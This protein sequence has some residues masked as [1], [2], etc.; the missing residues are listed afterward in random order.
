VLDMSMPEMDGMDLAGEI[1]RRRTAQELPIVMLTSLGQRQALRAGQG[2]DL[3]ACLSK[4]IKAGQL[5][6]TLVA[7]LQGR[8]P[9]A[10]PTSAAPA[11][12]RAQAQPLRVLLAE[13]N[14][15]GQRV[16]KRL[17]QHLGYEPDLA[18]DGKQVLQAVAR[19]SYD[20]ILM[21][22]QMPEIDGVQA[23]RQIVA[24]RGAAGRPRIIAM[25]ANAMPGDRETYIEAGMDGYL[26]K[27]IELADLAAVLEQVR[28]LIRD[29]QAATGQGV[30]DPAR[31]EHLRTLQDQSQPSLV[32]EL[33]DLFLNDSAGHVHRIVQAH[34][35]ADAA[36]LRALAHRFLSATQNI[37]ALA[38]SN[39][40]ADIER[41]AKAGQLSDVAPLLSDLQR[42]RE[43]AQLALQT[44]RMRY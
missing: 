30:L 14:V 11:P 9:G 7:V 44:L 10:E 28:L 27:P 25:T 38:L 41:L 15:T 32:R 3:V 36:S 13:D 31:L 35:A 39:L 40:C 21:D 20:V 16:M 18:A 33:I 12:T 23:A 37:G 5:F 19:R 26:P 42:E 6:N 4:P 29:H 34:E 8:H 43:R 22:I 2:A 1:R 24:Q 17:L